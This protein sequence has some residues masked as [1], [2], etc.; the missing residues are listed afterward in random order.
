MTKQAVWR[1]FVPIDGARFV[2]ELTEG[3]TWRPHPDGGVIILHPD[4]RPLWCRH[5]GGAYVQDW[6]DVLPPQDQPGQEQREHQ[7]ENV[8]VVGEVGAEKGPCNEHPGES[9]G[10]DQ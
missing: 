7:Q 9:A 2:R 3:E 1:N 6:L 10:R 5:E 4:R 8:F